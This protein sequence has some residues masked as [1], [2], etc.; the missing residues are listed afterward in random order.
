MDSMDVSLRRFKIL[1]P[2]SFAVPKDHP[3]ILEIRQR[4]LNRDSEFQ[5][6]IQAN[7]PLFVRERFVEA[8]V[9]WIQSVYAI[10]RPFVHDD[11]DYLR[12]SVRQ[13]RCTVRSTSQVIYVR[14]AIQYL[15][16]LE[17][18][19]LI[20][21]MLQELIEENGLNS[22]NDFQKIKFVYSYILNHVEYDHSLVNH[23]AYHALFE[24]KAVCEG[25]A[26]LVYRF[27]SSV[28][29]PCRIILGRGL[30]E[31]HAWNI[32]KLEDKW[33]YLDVTWDLYEERSFLI[34]RN[35]QWF[36]KGE[37]DFPSHVRDALYSNEAFDARYPIAEKGYFSGKN[38][39][40]PLP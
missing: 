9:S 33:F 1:H 2:L 27:L 18:E 40:F 20:R 17:Q 25:C 5:V 31:R 22:K 39:L 19:R 10:R 38:G 11:Y 36:L 6:T 35:L 12:R 4:L 7:D 8:A 3:V 24:G 14:Y 23:S 37:Q 13:V 26:A 28:N 15:T 32:V 30:R 16:T 29:I 21:E 34:W